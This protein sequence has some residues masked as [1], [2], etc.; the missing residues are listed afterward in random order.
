MT[1]NLAKKL[2]G[3]SIKNSK[4]VKGKMQFNTGMQPATAFLR[5]ESEMSRSLGTRMGVELW[6]WIATRFDLMSWRKTAYHTTGICKNCCQAKKFIH[7]I[8]NGNSKWIE[9][10]KKTVPF[11]A[12]WL[13]GF[14]KCWYKD[15]LVWGTQ[16][17]E[18]FNM[19]WILHIQLSIPCHSITFNNIL[20]Y[21]RSAMGVTKKPRPKHDTR[22]EFFY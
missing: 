16:I 20:Y 19:Y 13:F 3:S 7:K 5:E 2:H 10:L 6:P 4:G 8:E 9:R 15:H 22:K 12:I 21:F 1:D 14:V 17:R 11:D 18:L